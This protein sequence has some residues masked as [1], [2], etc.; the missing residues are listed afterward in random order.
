MD[1]VTTWRMLRNDLDGM[2]KAREMNYRKAV[3]M[4]YKENPKDLSEKH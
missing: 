2:L 1:E 4:Y 3:E